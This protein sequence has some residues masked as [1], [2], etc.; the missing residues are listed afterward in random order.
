MYLSPGIKQNDKAIQK[1]N[2]K[3]NPKSVHSFIGTRN[4]IVFHFLQFTNMHMADVAAGLELACRF[5]DDMIQ[6]CLH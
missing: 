4:I 1:Q 5:V 6:F 2:E 3:K